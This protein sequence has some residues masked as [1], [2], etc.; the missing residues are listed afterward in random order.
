IETLV[1]PGQAPL[2]MGTFHSLCGRMLRRDGPEVGIDRGYTIYDEADRLSA[3][4]RVMVGLN[5]DL[6]RF[7]PSAVV[8]RIS[9]AKNELQGPAEFA[10]GAEDYFSEVVSRVYAPYDKALRD[11]SA[12]DFDDMLLL[13]ARLFQ[14]H[15]DSLARWQA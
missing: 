9:R 14:E 15:P 11:A 4:K 2:W 7:P 8:A 13:T 3:V 5:L 12:V 10:A 1:G 6:K